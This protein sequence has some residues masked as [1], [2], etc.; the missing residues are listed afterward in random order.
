[1]LDTQF[2]KKN[3]QTGL[4][5]KYLVIIGLPGEKKTCFG[6]RFDDVWTNYLNVVTLYTL[7]IDIDKCKLTSVLLKH[8]FLTFTY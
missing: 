2:P 3:I 8:T 4:K 7:Q 1:M 5:Y 6:R